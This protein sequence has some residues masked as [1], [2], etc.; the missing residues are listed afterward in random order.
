MDMQ[1]YALAVSAGN[2]L[3]SK[4]NGVNWGC[5]NATA[6]VY[7]DKDPDFTLETVCL[8]HMSRVESGSIA[9]V[10]MLMDQREKEGFLTESEALQYMHW[11]LVDSPYAETFI[12][13]SAHQAL[14][15]KYTISDSMAPANLMVGGMVAVRRLWEFPIIARIFCDLTNR[16]VNKN[17]AYVLGHTV[18]GS[19]ERE[20]SYDFSTLRGAHTSIGGAIAARAAGNFIKGVVITKSKPYKESTYYY[21][22]S[23]QFGD[24]DYSLHTFLMGL[25]RN[26]VEEKEDKNPFAKAR[27]IRANSF[28][29]DELIDHLVSHEKTILKKCGVDNA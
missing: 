20:G 3:K 24:E 8:A 6:I 25:P 21:G 1:T 5:M 15:D 10:N 2:E 12:S 11:L 27:V 18:A 17:L 13:K 28:T 7:P 26:K 22:Y 16:G 4:M 9:V 29:Y 19:F 23:T 14:L